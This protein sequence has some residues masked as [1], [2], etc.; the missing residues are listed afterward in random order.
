[1]NLHQP[2]R[3][4]FD[5]AAK[6]IQYGVAEDKSDPSRLPD[7]TLLFK[8]AV[9]AAGIWSLIESP[10]EIGS[11]GDFSALLALA[12][13]KPMIAALAWWSMRR[14]GW[15]RILF[16]FLCSVSAMEITS[17]LPSEFAFSREIF[18]LSAIECATKSLVVVT[19]F[20][21][22]IRR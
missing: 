17:A 15:P 5:D 18:C 10:W 1:M 21:W 22:W 20:L 3:Q 16:V 7:T 6:H 8:V 19:H 9:Y 4:I 14:Q 11:F 2:Y 12:I 13:T